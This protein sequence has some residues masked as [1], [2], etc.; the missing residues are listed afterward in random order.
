MPYAWVEP[1]LYLEHQGV[2]VY[3]VYRNDFMD[4]GAYEYQYT[5]DI[6][7][8]CEGQ[9]DIRDLAAYRPGEDHQDILRRAIGAGE[10]TADGIVKRD[11]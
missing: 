2:S 9:F 3:H 10:L 7:E 1:G 8:R 6:Q 11:G 4:A 5:V